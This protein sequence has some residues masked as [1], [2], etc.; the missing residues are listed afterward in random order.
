MSADRLAGVA[1]VEQLF[2]TVH[3]TAVRRQVTADL[4]VELFELH[5]VLIEHRVP[6][7]RLLLLNTHR[8]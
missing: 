2:D 4:D 6:Q 7:L 8:R 1:V 5:L 3:V